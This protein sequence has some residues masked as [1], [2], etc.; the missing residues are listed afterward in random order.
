[1]ANFFAK[2]RADIKRAPLWVWV[3]LILTLIL[4]YFAWKNYQNSG[5][6]FSSSPST[7]TTGTTDSGGGGGGGSGITVPTPP[8][9]PSTPTLT[10]PSLSDL[11]SNAPTLDVTAPSTSAGTPSI[12]GKR[13]A[14]DIRSNYGPA[15]VPAS[16]SSIFGKRMATDIRSNYGPAPARPSPIAAVTP[17]AHLQ[18]TNPPPI[19]L[20][21]H[22]SGGQI[23]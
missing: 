22:G 23:I 1:M 9:V 3:G 20:S 12:F 11:L 18:V 16:L 5:S 13:M 10:A 6:I 8:T 4:V 15:P 7:G 2:I 21:F 17:P 19:R 14:T